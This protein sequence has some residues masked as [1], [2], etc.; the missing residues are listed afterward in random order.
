MRFVLALA[1]VCLISCG[2]IVP[3]QQIITTTATQTQTQELQTKIESTAPKPGEI[4][5]VKVAKERVRA[6]EQQIQNYQQLLQSAK[7]D[8]QAA[9]D[10]RISNWCLWA[11]GIF[12]VLAAA[13]FIAAWF[14]PVL[15]V[16]LAYAG[17]ALGVLSALSLWLSNHVWVVNLVGWVTFA[18]IVVGIIGGIVALLI[19]EIGKGHIAVQHA[20]NY[21]DSLEDLIKEHLPSINSGG[22]AEVTQALTNGVLKAKI[23]VAKNQAK[24]KVHTL[25][26]DIRTL[27]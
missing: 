16:R 27:G 26:D 4:L 3:K 14:L 2:Q 24:D 21:A 23:D 20:S 12:A 19:R 13:A 10:N 8:Q 5:E 22:V 18:V 25:T 6:I 1:T 7:A 11:T 15:K 17:A 9:E